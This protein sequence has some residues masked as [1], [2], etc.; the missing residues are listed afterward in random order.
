MRIGRSVMSFHVARPDFNA[1]ERLKKLYR[2]VARKFHPDLAADE[3]ERAHRHQLMIEVNRAY[4]TGSEERLQAL[5]EA[6]V[7][8]PELTRGG[9]LAAELVQVMHQL[10]KIKERLIAIDTQIAETAS[11]EIYKLKL[12]ADEAEALG[13]NFLAELVAQVIAR[14]PKPK[15]A[16]FIGRSWSRSRLRS[17]EFIRFLT[18]P[19]NKLKG[20]INAASNS[21][22][23]L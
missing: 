9:D 12:R 4:E 1:S 2:E 10:A 22:V 8:C 17:N 7:N 5:L 18:P 3:Q 15:I 20:V 6:E 13:R 11:S 16:W 14:L 19:T 23:R 21:Y